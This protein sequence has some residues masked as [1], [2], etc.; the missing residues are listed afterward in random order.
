MTE[1]ALNLPR[2]IGII[3]DGNGRWASQRGMERIEGH[4]KGME[5][6]RTIVTHLARKHIPYITL[7]AFSTENW[8]R[9]PA[10]VAF[11]NAALKSY[12]EDE[13]PVLMKNNIR[14]KA[15]GTL[16]HFSPE[17]VHRIS[18]AENISKSN[19]GSTLVL[20]ISYG[21]QQEIADS[22]KALARKLLAG[23][24]E[25]DD[26]TPQSLLDNCYLPELAECDFIVRTSGEQRL[27]NFLTLQS[28]YTELYFTQ[29]LWPDFTPEEMDVALEDYQQR[30]RRFGG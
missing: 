28:A 14:F 5:V 30:H 16:S 29:T 9:D 11:L 20:A 12:L 24:I 7:Y 23:Q 27:S 8:N 10:E 3:M 19:T 15:I 13:L 17:L 4:A 26:I 6:A 1:A 22:C 25:L 2:H 18:E 21:G